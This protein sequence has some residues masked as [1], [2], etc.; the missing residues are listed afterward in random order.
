MNLSCIHIV[1]CVLNLQLNSQGVKSEVVN[2]QNPKKNH[3][4]CVHLFVSWYSSTTHFKTIFNFTIWNINLIER[5]KPYW[6]SLMFLEKKL[7]L[8]LKNIYNINLNNQSECVVWFKNI[9]ILMSPGLFDNHPPS[10]WRFY[11]FLKWMH[12]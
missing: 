2:L 4:R 8:K 11:T 1:T 5:F 9:I 12:C 6:R 10:Y 7:K 3:L